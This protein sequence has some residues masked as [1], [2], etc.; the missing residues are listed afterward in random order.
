MPCPFGAQAPIRQSAKY[1]HLR[2][3]P[4]SLNPRT[5]AVP[6]VQTIA[7]MS[8]T[9][10]GIARSPGCHARPHVAATGAVPNL[11]C[12]GALLITSRTSLPCKLRHW[13]AA[14]IG[15]ILGRGFHR[16][17]NV[18]TR[19]SHPIDQADAPRS[20]VEEWW[21]GSLGGR[22]C[23]QARPGHLPGWALVSLVRERA[24]G[25]PS[26]FLPSCLPTPP[27]SSSSTHEPA[28]CGSSMTSR[29]QPMASTAPF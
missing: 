20:V 23:S 25:R 12:E 9:S 7:H 5:A 13:S 18:P 28:A 29:R 19:Q 26:Q 15:K 1:V 8:Y 11:G 10:R 24:H 21:F 14:R 17:R 6:L 4:R 3:H 27:G 22:C 2:A 16:V